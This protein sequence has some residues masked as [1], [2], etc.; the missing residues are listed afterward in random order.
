[1]SRRLVWWGVLVGT[2]ATLN[3]SAR[4]ASG[5]PDP[6]SLYEY[7][8]AIGGV[9]QYAVMFVAIYAIAGRSREL[10]G[11]RRPPSWPRALGLAALVGVGAAV[12]IELIDPFLHAG[13]EQGLTPKHWEHAHLGAYM[14]NLAVVALIDPVVEESIFRGAGYSLLARYGRWTAILLIGFFFAL[15]HGL[16][17]AFP[18]LFIL[19]AAL[20]WLRAKTGSTY[21]GMLVHGLFNGVTLIAVIFS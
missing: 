8:N 15:A 11:W 9:V 3:Y 17:E 1:M 21:P 4:I 20:A 10:L 14:A 13:S 7:V 18:E 5:K 19:G 6:N 16:V 2:L 12:A